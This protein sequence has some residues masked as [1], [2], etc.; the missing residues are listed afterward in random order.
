MGCLDWINISDS[1][2]SGE[3]QA[4]VLTIWALDICRSGESAGSRE[5]GFLEQLVGKTSS[6]ANNERHASLVV[7]EDV[8]AVHGKTLLIGD[9]RG[10][11][12]IF[13]FLTPSDREGM[14]GPESDG[15][16][17]QVGVLA[18]AEPPWASH[19]DGHTKGVS[20]E[21]LDIATGTTVSDVARDKADESP[22]SL[23]DP[24]REYA[25]EHELLRA[26][27][28]VDPYRAERDGSTDNVAVQENLV[29][30]VTH[31]GWRLNQEE[32]E[33][34]SSL[35]M[36]DVVGTDLVHNLR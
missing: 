33:C 32:D 10:N 24:E 20:G 31:W 1:E 29:E 8:L 23:H 17:V 30:G 5:V 34:D 14:V 12:E 27:L 36:L 3:K 18:G 19:A 2:K 11:G 6:S 7:L 13:L 15:R 4:S 21:N 22:G 25:V 16:N 35:W 9:G 26:L 28:E